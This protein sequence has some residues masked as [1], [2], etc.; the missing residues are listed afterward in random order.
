MS[1]NRWPCNGKYICQDK[2][3]FYFGG[4]ENDS[5][6]R[7]GVVMLLSNEIAKYVTRFAC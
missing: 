7:H 3:T 2:T 1:E 6:R 5:Q 4:S